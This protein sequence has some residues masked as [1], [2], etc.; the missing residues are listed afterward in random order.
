MSIF[1]AADIRGHYG[2][3]L[4]DDDAY[5]LGMAIAIRCGAVAVLVGGDGRQSTPTL[6]SFLIQG[7][8]AGGCHVIDLGI[9]PTP[10]LYFARR[11]LN[12]TTAVMVTASHNPPE[13]NGFKVALGQ[14]PITPDEIQAL[15]DVMAAISRPVNLHE[16]YG[17]QARSILP[18]YI[19]SV[20]SQASSLTG[21]H[22]VVDCADGV[23]GLVAHATWQATEAHVSFLFDTVDG[24][25]PHHLPNPANVS[26]LQA[27]RRAVLDKGADLGV[28]YD[29][30]GDR[31]A[32]IDGTGQPLVNDKAIVLFACDALHAQTAPIVYD[33]KCSL[34]VPETIREQGGQPVMER[35]GYTFIKTT[36]LRLQAPYAGEL[37]GHHFFH[38]LQGDDGVIASLKMS[39]II[40]ESQCNLSKLAE[41]IHTYPITPDI[42][43]HMGDD[44]AE[45]I[46]SELSQHLSG[47]ASISKLD[48]L[49]VE[50][51]DGW[52]LV[53]RSI[54]EHAITLRFEGKDKQALS[55]II[56][57]FSTASPVLAHYIK[58][59]QLQ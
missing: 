2:S 24:R 1:K 56:M 42:R 32:F 8:S 17:A 25:F 57:R 59:E 53:R 48:G 3:E 31:V 20:R 38:A 49:R 9:L 7:L 45:R 22:I 39:R 50:F 29:G 40:H 51:D 52:G 54:T 14:I 46:L 30:D 58:Q 55:R 19:D 23:A 34:I 36:F 13:D 6:K 41:S 15:A 16:K 27:L 33:Q 44:V 5:R 11:L 43:I 21:M 28:A 35:S 26:N 4:H 10:A 37:T 12:V 47:E 18:E